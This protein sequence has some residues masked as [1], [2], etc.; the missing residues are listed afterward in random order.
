[1]ERK[2]RAF[3]YAIAA[4]LAVFIAVF[5]SIAVLGLTALGWQLFAYGCGVAG[6]VGVL[7]RLDRQEG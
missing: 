6:F 2:R 3:V 7:D 4:F 5:T 1:M